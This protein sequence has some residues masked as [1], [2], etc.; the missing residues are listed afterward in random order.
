[1]PED[2]VIPQDKNV[3]GKKRRN[4][5]SIFDVR[6]T[7]Q[8]IFFLVI[9]AIAVNHSLEAAGT[10]FPILSTASTHAICP[11]GGVVSVYNYATTGMLVKKIHGSALVLMY[12]GFTLALLAGPAFC[13]WACP[14]GSFQE[15]L[16]KLGKKLFR[17]RFNQLIPSRVDGWLRYLR[18]VVLIWVVWVTAVSARL[19]FADYDPYFALFNFWGGEIAISAL[20]IL[21]MVI[22][23]SLFVER[24]FCKYACPYGALLGIFNLFRIFKVKRN[25]D[26]F[27]YCKLCDRAC[28]MNIKV[29]AGAS[30]RNH[31]C[32]SCLKCTSEQQC[33]VS[34]T[35]SMTTGKVT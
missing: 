7:I 30:V 23:L 34:A 33:P 17:K 8:I 13:G 31:Q 28:P 14:F 2:K 11:F 24:P 25:A 6:L 26:S 35:V 18:Y 1:M 16:G 32:I 3:T 4:N 5:R 12:I 29:S 22:F 15:W 27:I 20:V 9:A 19:I 21:C 10:A